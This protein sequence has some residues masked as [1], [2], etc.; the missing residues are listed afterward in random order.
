ME[1]RTE[2]GLSPYRIFSRAE[3]AQLR[4]DTPMTLTGDEVTRLRSLHDR[5][6]MREVEEIYLPL[7]RLLSL[8]VAATQRLFHA[9]QNFL[10]TEDSKV[11]Y[12]IGVA[13]SVAVGK[14]T[15]ARVLQA[16]LARWPNVPKVGLVT[17]DGFLFP[18]AILT[19]EGLM[20]KKGFPESY[21]LPA[22]LRF[23]SDIKAGRRPVRAPVYSHLLYDV[24]PNQWVEIDRPDI[25]IV[26]GLNVLQTG[27]PP[28]DGKAIP[29]VSDFFDFSVYLDADE[30]VLQGW[31]VD[32]FLTLRGTAF[33]DPKSYFHRYSTLS[34]EEAVATATSIWQ[35]I[36]LVN[37]HESI[38]PT[39]RRADLI[40]KKGE[41]HLVGEVALRRL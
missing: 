21:D 2:D 14:S 18:N 13:G 25:L 6:D 9:Q 22:L 28:R 15:T 5:L 35:R 11:P 37:L 41:N 29:Y 32:R 36:N 40:L 24:M 16:L 38:L 19:R 1:Q 34:D 7:S 23:L 17:T 8:Y 31:Y 10:G 39:R 12:I 27:R 33:R 4:E 30:E 3:W 26:E 20:E